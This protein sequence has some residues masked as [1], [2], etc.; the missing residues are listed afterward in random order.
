MGDLDIKLCLM[1][2]QRS[3]PYFFVTFGNFFPIL[4]FLSLTLNKV[5][6]NSH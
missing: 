3:S 4:R 2:N 5:L 6:E 1:R